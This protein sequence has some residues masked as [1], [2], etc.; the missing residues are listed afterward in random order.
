MN[1][2]AGQPPFVE[3]G[4][5]PKAELDGMSQAAQNQTLNT[6]TER[7][8]EADHSTEVLSVGFM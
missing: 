5:R 3:A 2:G 6:G 1:R 8:L 7:A 4:N